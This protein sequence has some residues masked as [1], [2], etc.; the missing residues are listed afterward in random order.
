MNLE[1][2]K[3]VKTL[4][5]GIRSKPIRVEGS[6]GLPITLGEK[7]KKR[8]LMQLLMVVKIDVP[9]NAI[10]DSPLLNELY[11]VLSS[12]YLLMKFK[13]DKGIAFVKGDQVKARRSVYWLLRLL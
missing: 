1:H 10:F 8:T 13:T 11:I 9:Y 12:Q 2:L 5:E 7:D 6:V 4:L 3:R